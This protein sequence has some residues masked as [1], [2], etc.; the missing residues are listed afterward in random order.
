MITRAQLVVKH[1]QLVLDLRVVGAWARISLQLLGDLLHKVSLNR[2]IKRVRH[3][4]IRD[5]KTGSNSLQ[6][7]L[8]R[9]FCL[10]I[11]LVDDW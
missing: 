2:R 3:I 9:L 8:F 5:A 11:D 7:L 4:G 6:N 10:L 1:F